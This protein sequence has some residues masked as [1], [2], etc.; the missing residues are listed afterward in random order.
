[1]QDKEV[2]VFK[3]A[4]SLNCHHIVVEGYEY[5]NDS[6]SYVVGGLMPLVG[7]LKASR[8]YVTGQT[9]RGSKTLM[10]KKRSRNVMLL[11]QPPGANPD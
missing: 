7:S 11:P 10:R 3:K 1:M 8:P 5:P 6:R 2:W 9:K 4:F